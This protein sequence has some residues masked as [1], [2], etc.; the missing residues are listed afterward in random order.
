MSKDPAH[1]NSRE[2]AQRAVLKRLAAC[3]G[4]RYL[5][6]GGILMPL[7]VGNAARPTM[8]LDF[9]GTDP[10]DEPRLLNE[11]RRGLAG[12]GEREGDAEVDV[13]SL[14]HELLYAET[15][16]PGLRVTVDVWLPDQEVLSQR[17]DFGF[18]DP[19]VPPPERIS[20]PIGESPALEVWAVRPELGF[21]WKLHELL[22]PRCWD[23]KHLYDL[24]AMIRLCPLDR[25]LLGTAIRT[26]FDAHRT[27]TER[28]E[29]LFTGDFGHSTAR[30]RT[31]RQFRKKYPNLSIPEDRFETIDRLKQFVKGIERVD[32]Q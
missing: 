14:R 30:T 10:F 9:A 26:A 17:M 23:F 11:I 28:M 31:W 18:H 12:K 5:L 19:I 6:R 21:A 8:D 13:A 24:D 20:L 16:F 3:G 25:D 27:P 7:W 15:P 1:R 2:A 32:G 4:D 22:E 29:R